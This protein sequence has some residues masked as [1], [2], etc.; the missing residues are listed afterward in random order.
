M[1]KVAVTG[2]TGFLGRALIRA[3]VER[4]AQIVALTRPTSDRR[5]LDD[6]AIQWVEGDVLDAESLVELTRDAEWLVHA[7]GMLG[8]A[9]VPESRYHDLHVTGTDNVLAAAG[10]CRR[11]LFVSSPG[12]LGP[13]A[14][15]PADELAPLAPSNAYERSKAA[16]EGVVQEH[17]TKGAPVIIGRP[18]FVYGPGDHHVL[19]LF[20]AVQQGRFFYIA[21]GR[22]HCH[23]TFIDDAVDGLVRCL[24][25]GAPG[26]IYHIAGPQPVTFR[27][28]GES[29]ADA[30]GVA[31]PWLSVP[32]VA[33]WLGALVLEGAG[34]VSGRTPPL[35][36]S[37]VAF[38]SEDRQFSWA[39]AAAK[40]GYQPQVDLAT[41]VG[42]TVNWYRQQGLLSGAS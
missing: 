36:R 3:L 33:A 29:M 42:L 39:K 12:V 41:G 25:D 15:P 37:G 2:A 27:Q 38:F 7:A 26:E 10:H 11:I 1:S 23:P 24:I 22:H 13:I 34:K 20:R 35:S 5:P 9:G 8:Q 4:G 17:V 28:L 6:L 18:E 30:L 40:L 16:A 21:G 14:G 31:R 19:G 32:R